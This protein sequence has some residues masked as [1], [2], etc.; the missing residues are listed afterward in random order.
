MPKA[1]DFIQCSHCGAKDEG[2]NSFTVRR[3]EKSGCWQLSCP[4][5]IM[6]KLCMTKDELQSVWNS[7]PGKKVEVPVVEVKHP[8][9]KGTPGNPTGQGKVEITSDNTEAF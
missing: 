1:K 4:C 5:G 7:R 9:V 6:T 3:F 8:P 2:E